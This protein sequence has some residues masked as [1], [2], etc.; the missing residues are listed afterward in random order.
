MSNT[1]KAAEALGSVSVKVT[2][3][4]TKALLS[5][6]KGMLKQ[7]LNSQPTKKGVRNGQFS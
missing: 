6:G 4:L 2:V 5:V 3:G 7:L 1:A